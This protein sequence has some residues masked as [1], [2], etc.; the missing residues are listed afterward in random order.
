MTVKGE[1]YF[2]RTRLNNVKNQL[3]QIERAA[4]ATKEQI[5][6]SEDLALDN[7]GL[8]ASIIGTLALVPASQ[9]DFIEAEFGKICS[10]AMQNY[11]NE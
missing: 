3:L 2:C 10:Q 5:I 9:V 6:H 7:V 1:K 8:M 4:N 11:N